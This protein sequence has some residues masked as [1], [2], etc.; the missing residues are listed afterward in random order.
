METV[1][2]G[3][4][5]GKAEFRDRKELLNTSIDAEKEKNNTGEVYDENITDI[6]DWR[7]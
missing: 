5:N 7:D 6:N 1:F 3:F 2:T 4:C